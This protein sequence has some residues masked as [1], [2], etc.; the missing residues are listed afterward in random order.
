MRLSSFPPHARGWT[1]PHR[2]HARPQLV[3]PA[4]AWMDPAPF[5]DQG[6]EGSFPRTRGDGPFAN[7]L[8]T[9]VDLFPPH[10]RGWTR[11]QGHAHAVWHVSPARAG[12]DPIQLRRGLPRSRFPRT[13]GDGPSKGTDQV[14]APPFP[15]HARGWTCA[16]LGIQRCERVSPARAGMDLPQGWR[17]APVSSFPRTRGDGPHAWCDGRVHVPFPPHA[18][19][20]TSDARSGQF[21]QNV[22]PARA[23]MDPSTRGLRSV[24][25]CFPRTRGDGPHPAPRATE[26][27]SRVRFPRTRGRRIPV[28]P[29]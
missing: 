10:A 21:S 24:Q 16:R 23:G 19:G 14:G 8:Q 4:R 13:R 9:E 5:C 17:A 20:W 29:L 1:L 11:P 12:M 7:Y 18:R 26:A 6:A 28:K 3:S 27:R 2:S 22:S 25:A 15:P